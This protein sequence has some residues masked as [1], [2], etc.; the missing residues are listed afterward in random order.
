MATSR[1]PAVDAG[2]RA[3]WKKTSEATVGI[4][5]IQ[6]GEIKDHGSGVL[7]RLAD[8]FFIVRA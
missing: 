2:L 1:D 3:V 5:G 8:A 4:F 7:F 6:D